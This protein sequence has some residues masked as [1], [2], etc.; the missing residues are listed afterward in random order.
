[1]SNVNTDNP[2]DSGEAITPGTAISSKTRGIYVGGAGDVEAKLV[3]G[4]IV[5][6]AVPVGTILPIRTKLIVAANT[7]A[8]NLLGIW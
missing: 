5:F 7:T 1:M 3:G 8:T 6:S 2:A 4:N